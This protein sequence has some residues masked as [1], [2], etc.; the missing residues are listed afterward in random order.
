MR[1]S[2][3]QGDGGNWVR[4]PGESTKDT[5]KTIRAGKAG[6]S[7]RHLSSTRA[8]QTRTRDFGCQPAP[9]LPCALSSKKGGEENQTRA[10]AAAR[11]QNPV[12]CLKYELSRCTVAHT[13][14]CESRSREWLGAKLKA[15]LTSTE[16][17]GCFG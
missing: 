7:R 9:G 1:I 17:A 14:H 16:P 5:V 4:L 11:V 8:R 13:R 15:V 2:H 6:M 3:R 12:Y 10:K